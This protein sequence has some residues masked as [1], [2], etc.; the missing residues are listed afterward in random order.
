M[1]QEKDQKPDEVDPLTDLTVTSE[2]ADDVIAGV[3]N[4]GGPGGLIFSA[5]IE[6]VPI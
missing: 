3:R 6:T 5:T 4:V 1:N 2:E